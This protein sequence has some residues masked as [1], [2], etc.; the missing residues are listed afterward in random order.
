[1]FTNL[2]AWYTNNPKG[3]LVNRHNMD[4]TQVFPSYYLH[5]LP[6]VEKDV[7][8]IIIYTKVFKMV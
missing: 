8:S 2:N 5:I 1:M 4:F 7:V 3:F 6:M